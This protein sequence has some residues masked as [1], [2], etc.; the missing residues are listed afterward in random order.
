[1]YLNYDMFMLLLFLQHLSPHVF[2][3]VFLDAFKNK[4]I[5]MLL[6]SKKTNLL[7]QKSSICECKTSQKNVCYAFVIRVFPTSVTSVVCLH[8][9]DITPSGNPSH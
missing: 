9:P 4:L 7:V 8:P 5:Q 1:M 3:K 6:L 2:Q